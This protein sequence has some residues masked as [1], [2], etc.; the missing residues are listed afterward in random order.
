MC[1][2]SHGGLGGPVVRGRQPWSGEAKTE[3]GELNSP[4][5]R[6][7]LHTPCCTAITLPFFAGTT[8]ISAILRS[9]ARPAR[10]ILVTPIDRQ[11]AIRSASRPL[12]IHDGFGLGALR[13]CEPTCRATG[14]EWRCQ[15]VSGT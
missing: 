11:Q 14:A 2:A 10:P 6:L 4:H 8:T 9:C 12:G 7:F 5:P 13:F 1:F 3:L 15:P